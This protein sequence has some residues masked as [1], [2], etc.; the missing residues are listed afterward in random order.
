VLDRVEAGI[1]LT[2]RDNVLESND[3]SLALADRDGGAEAVTLLDTT[4]RKSAAG[5]RRPYSGILAGYYNRDVRDVRLAGT[6]CEGGATA[7]VTWAGTGR[8]EVQM[9]G[10]LSVRV[11]DGNGQPVSGAIVRVLD[12]EG[13][14]V[15][16][17][18]TG[19]DG[20]TRE[21]VVIAVVCRPGSPR[22]VEERRGPHRV[23]ASREGAAAEGSVELSDKRTLPLTLR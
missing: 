3:V 17:G 5:P 2:I 9:G 4:L 18:R 21:M 13:S 23:L 15:A 6:G 10:I 16:A 11:V 12:R 20:L 14:E 22:G 8:R 7:T 19:V 1:N